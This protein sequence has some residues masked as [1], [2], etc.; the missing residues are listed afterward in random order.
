MNCFRA[1]P[2]LN[3][4]QLKWFPR[5]EQR[6]PKSIIWVSVSHAMAELLVTRVAFALIVSSVAE[7]HDANRTKANFQGRFSSRLN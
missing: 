6:Q 3:L 7:N 1:K 5:A 4:I 2:S